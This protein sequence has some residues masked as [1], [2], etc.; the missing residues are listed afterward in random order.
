V[1]ERLFRKT[2]DL[3][4]E[5]AHERRLWAYRRAAWTVD[6]LATSVEESYNTQ[7]IKGLMALPSV[8]Q[9]IARLI[10]DYLE[11]WSKPASP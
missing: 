3:E 7:G 5:E 6:E 2:W 10:A 11:K 4:L 1:A 8:G 9:R